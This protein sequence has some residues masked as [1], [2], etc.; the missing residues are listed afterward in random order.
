[1]TGRE[2]LSIDCDRAPAAPAST[3][4]RDEACSDPLLHRGSLELYQRIESMEQTLTL[5][6]GGVYLFGQ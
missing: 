1:M 6:L 4:S 5:Q 2:F 3:S